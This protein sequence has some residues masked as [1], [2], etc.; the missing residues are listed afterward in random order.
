MKS[1]KMLK[2]S[3]REH[4]WVAHD[5]KIPF[6][7][8]V[9]CTASSK[10][11]VIFLGGHIHLSDPAQIQH[12]TFLTRIQRKE[13]GITRVG[14]LSAASVHLVSRFRLSDR[15]SS[16]KGASTVST[17]LGDFHNK[18][19]SWR[20]QR[21]AW[22]SSSEMNECRRSEDKRGGATEG[23]Q[24]L[25]RRVEGFEVS[26]DAISKKI[27]RKFSKY[28]LW[29]GRVFVGQWTVDFPAQLFFFFSFPVFGGVG[30]GGRLPD[31]SPAPHFYPF[32]FGKCCPPFSYIAWLKGRNCVL[33]NK[34][35]FFGGG[36]IVSNFEWC[37]NQIGLLQK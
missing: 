29:I 18:N 1:S 37:A 10:F 5:F 27:L 25:R 23:K 21:A 34:T 12:T 19:P 26:S 11:R 32:C 20:A 17:C 14:R 8:L 31:V 28:A 13:I 3:S 33:Q 4:T 7:Q 16:P 2:V 24:S 35:V 36:S 22:R 9:E 6:R 15:A 30:G